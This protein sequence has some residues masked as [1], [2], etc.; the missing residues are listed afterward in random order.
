[1]RDDRVASFMNRE[2][3]ILSIEEIAYVIIVG[4]GDYA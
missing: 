1:M 4:H 2:G 3:A